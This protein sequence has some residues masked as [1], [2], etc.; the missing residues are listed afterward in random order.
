VRVGEIT[1]TRLAERLYMAS[2][3]SGSNRSADRKAYGR[4]KVS[5]GNALFPA[6]TELAWGRRLRDIMML[7]TNDLGGADFVSAA[8]ASIIRRAATE[9]VE[10]ELIEF[11]FAKNG[12]GASAEDLDLYARI[13]NSLRRHLEALGLKRV[14]KDIT[15]DTLETIAAEIE[16]ERNATEQDQRDDIGCS[17]AGDAT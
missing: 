15:P 6:S 11:R 4:S 16:A 9:T 2:T 5:N 14:A 17:D 13:S 3:A 1:S 8:E 7:H 12:K 10:L